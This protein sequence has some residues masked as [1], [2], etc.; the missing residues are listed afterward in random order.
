MQVKPD[1]HAALATDKAFEQF[2]IA[3]K[4]GAGG[5]RRRVRLQSAL[6][7]LSMFLAMSNA[8]FAALP[9]T[10]PMF[11]PSSP[12]GEGSRYTYAPHE[13]QYGNQYTWSEATRTSAWTVSGE[14]LADLGAASEFILVVCM[15]EG[16]ACNAR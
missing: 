11:I 7:T 4:G 16:P 1:Q 3:I 13:H 8:L 15:D 12:R 2:E 9:I 10:W 14:L 6:A 5:K